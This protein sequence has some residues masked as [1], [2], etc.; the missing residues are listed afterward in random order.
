MIHAEHNTKM[1]PGAVAACVLPVGLGLLFTVGLLSSALHHELFMTLPIALCFVFGAPL[2]AWL[3]CRRLQRRVDT[4]RLAPW[5]TSFAAGLKWSTLVHF[6]AALIY[7]IGFAVWVSHEAAL[8]G[9]GLDED[10]F[11]IGFMS[12]YINV[13][14]WCILTLP[15]ALICS[16][17]FWAVTKF[18]E[19]GSDA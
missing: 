4:K 19:D 15:F 8:S 1:L 16:T 9:R 10:L 18:P 5:R 6:G 14:L 12:A 17:I 7:T 11:L 3:A 13:I 2:S